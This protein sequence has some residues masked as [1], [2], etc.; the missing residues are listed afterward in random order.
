M[1]I[2]YDYDPHEERMKRVLEGKKSKP[3]EI[4]YQLEK[5]SGYTIFMY[6]ISMVA[7]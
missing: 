3:E 7:I 1:S 2:G 4:S 5:K 6:I